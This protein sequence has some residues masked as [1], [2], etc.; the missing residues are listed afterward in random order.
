MLFLGELAGD[1]SNHWPVPGQFTGSFTET[2]QSGEIDSELH[3]TQGPAGG[4]LLLS[5]VEQIQK[6][7]GADLVHTPRVVLGA[8][9][10]GQQVDS[11]HGGMSVSSRQLHPVETGGAVIICL[12][13]HQSLLQSLLIAIL[14]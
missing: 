9:R 4:V 11:P 7:I 6:H 3:P 10:S 2:D 13:S 8:G 14:G 1:I 12:D 5:A